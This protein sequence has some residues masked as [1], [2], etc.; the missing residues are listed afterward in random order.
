[1]RLI[2]LI[3]LLT[4]LGALTARADTL[5]VTGVLLESDGSRAGGYTVKIYVVKPNLGVTADDT[6]SNGIYTIVKGDVEES[7]VDSWYVICEQGPKKVVAKLVF[8]RKP[9]NI[10]QA[11]VEDLTLRSSNEARYSPNGAVET[12]R[13]VTTIKSIKVKSGEQR[14]ETANEEAEREVA[15]ILG[16]TDLGRSPD[17]TLRQ[18]NQAVIQTSDA[19]LPRMSLM[20]A[21]KF[22]SLRN[23][24][25]FTKL[26]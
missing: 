24:P 11:K 8:N 18:I 13:T 7:T 23:R 15:R 6:S 17:T 14:L 20:N 16:R 25:V 22:A 12:I 4:T 3:S 5:V 1:M 26:P 21:E 19:N 10:W 9:N 2:A